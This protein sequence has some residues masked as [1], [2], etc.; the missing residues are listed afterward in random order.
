MKKQTKGGVI[1]TAEDI[2]KDFPLLKD[3]D[4]SYLDSGAT[5]HKPKQVID[6]ISSFF[7]FSIAYE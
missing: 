5:T 6:A 4:I 2:K 1:M 7:K 3:N